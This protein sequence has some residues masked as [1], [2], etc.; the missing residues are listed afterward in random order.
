MTGAGGAANTPLMLDI[1]S[2]GGVT[3]AKALAQGPYLKMRGAIGVSGGLWDR[4][5]GV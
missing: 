4:Q 3:D 5:R 1:L 2:S